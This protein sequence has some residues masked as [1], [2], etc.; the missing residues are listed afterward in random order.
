MCGPRTWQVPDTFRVPQA[1]G[2]TIDYPF[3]YITGTQAAFPS[4]FFT[5]PPDNPWIIAEQGILFN[6]A[7]Q[8]DVEYYMSEVVIPWGANTQIV[9]S[10]DML[11]V[12]T[13][14]ID[15][16][17]NL[18]LRYTQD[19]SL[20][21]LPGFIPQVGEDAG[22]YGAIN[23]DSYSFDAPWYS[24]FFDDAA[25][26]PESELPV[27]NI[28]VALET[29][30]LVDTV[31]SQWSDD[32]VNLWF[33]PFQTPCDRDDRSQYLMT[34]KDYASGD[35]TR[36]QSLNTFWFG[37]EEIDAET[38]VSNHYNQPLIIP[39]LAINDLSVSRRP[40][41]NLEMGTMG[42]L[43]LYTAY[44]NP[45]VDFTN[46]RYDLEKSSNVGIMVRDMTGKTVYASE[47]EFQGAGEHVF[48]LDV[49]GLACGAYTY[50]VVTDNGMLGGKFLVEK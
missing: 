11:G 47:T 22:F 3:G 34:F 33:L 44:P 7:F 14:S 42:N 32:T 18:T 41:R 17:G 38:G 48:E 15:I 20:G 50:M 8:P 35:I 49:T 4:E 1:D 26:E 21:D 43:T 16:N 5:N 45:A 31:E 36:V 37:P 46:I 6:L 25:L 24:V 27:G 2:D 39:V 13:Y 10:P 29:S 23:I 12:K 40:D 9:G 19:F 30:R 28:Y